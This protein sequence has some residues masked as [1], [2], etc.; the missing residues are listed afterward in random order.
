MDAALDDLLGG[1]KERA[2]ADVGLTSRVARAL[3]PLDA[4]LCG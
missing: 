2:Q 3:L 1:I 4:Y